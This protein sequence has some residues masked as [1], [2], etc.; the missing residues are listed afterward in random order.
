MEWVNAQSP[1]DG[2]LVARCRAGDQE[3]WRELV[4]RFSRYVFAIAVQATGSPSPTP[5]TSSRRSSRASTSG[6]G[7]SAT[8]RRPPLDRTA[9]APLL[10]RP[11]RAAAPRGASRSSSRARPTTRSTGSRRRSGCGGARPAL[12]S[13]AARCSTASSAATRAT[14]RSARRSPS[15]RARSRAGSHAASAQLRERY[16]SE[17]RNP[18][19]PVWWSESMSAYD[20]EKL[21]ELLRALRPRPRA[22]VEAA[23]E[24]PPIRRRDRRARRA[25]GGG[26]RYRKQLHRRPRRGLEAE[27]V[28]P[29]PI[30]LDSFENAS[31]ASDGRPPRPPGRRAARRAPAGDPVPGQRLGGGDRR[32]PWRPAC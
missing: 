2:E 12:A 5:R 16:T 29:N 8:T 10:R 7:S 9:H 30:V 18:A 14:G 32:S 31:S 1:T 17:G 22:W 13:R 28:E 11:P 20:E 3:A 21:G 6:S 23:Q 4:D 26:D 24:L 25:C 19:L 27:G 15:R